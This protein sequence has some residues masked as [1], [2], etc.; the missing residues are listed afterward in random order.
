MNEIKRNETIRFFAD[1]M[2]ECKAVAQKLRGDDREDEAVFAKIRL[3]VY[4]IFNTVFST[5]TQ[6][7]GQDDGKA[8]EFFLVRLQQI[9][10]SWR[11]ALANAQQHGET[12]KAY[13]EQIKLDVVADIQNAFDRL[14]EVCA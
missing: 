7:A 8:A 9:P 1:R 5:A 11:I 13:I 2:E 6:V 4:Q 3:N 10:Q 14:W 12:E